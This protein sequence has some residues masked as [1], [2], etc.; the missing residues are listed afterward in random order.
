MLK[1]VTVLSPNLVVLLA[2]ADSLMSVAFILA[3]IALSAFFIAA[4]MLLQY[5]ATTGNW[6][7][8][9]FEHSATSIFLAEEEDKAAIFKPASVID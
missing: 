8:L 7:P 1:A 6:R 9:S 2:F 4:T 5:F 3:G